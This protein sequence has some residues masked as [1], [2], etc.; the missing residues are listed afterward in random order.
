VKKI[1]KIWAHFFFFNFSFQYILT[2]VTHPLLLSVRPT[3][4]L[5]LRYT[6]HLLPFRKDQSSQRYPLNTALQAIIGLGI[7]SYIKAEQR[8]LLGE[9]GSQEQ[10]KE[11]ET[12]DS[13]CSES[14][15]LGQTHPD[16][17]CCFSLREALWA[18]LSWFCQLHSP[19]V[20]NPSSSYNSSFFFSTGFL[21]L[22]RERPRG[23]L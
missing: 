18:L 3:P 2:T 19:Y 15:D 1:K 16:S 11:S 4:L 10:T 13:H 8:N 6:S 23:N 7:I 9:K 17:D 5:S 14:Q 12:P 21:K 20:L 22:E